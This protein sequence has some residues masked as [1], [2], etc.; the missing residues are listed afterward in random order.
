M[1][2]NIHYRLQFHMKCWY[3]LVDSNQW[4]ALMQDATNGE[5]A[6]VDAGRW[7]VGTLHTFCAIFLEIPNC[8]RIQNLLTLKNP[9]SIRGVEPQSVKDGL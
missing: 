9:A 4:A 8:S 3:W 2:A 6:G 7:E 1:K 5:T